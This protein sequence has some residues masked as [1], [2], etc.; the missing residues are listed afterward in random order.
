MKTQLKHYP[1]TGDFFLDYEQLG[2][3]T[4]SP[5][6]L[7][8]STNKELVYMNQYTKTGSRTERSIIVAGYIIKNPGFL[9]RLKGRVIQPVSEAE[10]REV[11]SELKEKVNK[12]DQF[13]IKSVN[14]WG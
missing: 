12:P 8:L 3:G 6:H 2:I 13:R 1:T 7:Q 11:E 9:N 14:F 10:K 4:D 5:Q